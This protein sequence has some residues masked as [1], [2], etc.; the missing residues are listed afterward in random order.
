MVVGRHRRAEQSEAW[1]EPDPGSVLA[2]FEERRR[3]SAG[4]AR[5]HRPA[6][7]GA[8]HLRPDGPRLPQQWDGYAYA[9]AGTAP[10]LDAARVWERSPVRRWDSPGRRS[11]AA[12]AD[13]PAVVGRPERHGLLRPRQL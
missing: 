3:P 9:P 4:I 5:R 10:D 7:G 11:P 12:A 8:G 13:A 1:P 6:G 2:A